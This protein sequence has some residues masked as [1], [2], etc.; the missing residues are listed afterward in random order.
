MRAPKRLAAVVVAGAAVVAGLTGGPTAA[1][2]AGVYAGLGARA[3]VRG[4]RRRRSD[5][6][7]AQDLDALS[8]R[9][10]DLRAGSMLSSAPTVVRAP[11]GELVGAVERLAE[12]TGAP[13]ADLLDR[14]E[15][16][17]RATSRVHAS[18]RSEAAGVRA[19][20]LLLA[21]LPVGGVGLGYSI[22]VDPLAV[23]LHTPVGAVCA[24]GAVAL[25]AAGL[26]WSD[27]LGSPAPTP[28]RTR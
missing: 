2:A 19:T 27:R 16:D 12:R 15:A 17:A 28:G 22:G 1:L 7:H 18:A 13:A 24:L 6:E 23:L 11:L 21:V 9:A 4:A 26:L 10:A 8:C 5:R 20:A 3:A 25:H 14:V